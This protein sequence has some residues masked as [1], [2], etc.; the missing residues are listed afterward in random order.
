ME[1]IDRIQEHYEK[2]PA[3]DGGNFYFDGPF[4]WELQEEESFPYYVGACEF[5]FTLAA[6]RIERSKFA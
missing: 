2:Q 3:L 6:P 5:S 4:Y 1:V